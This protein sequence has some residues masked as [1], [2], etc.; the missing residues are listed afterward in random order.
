MKP[1]YQRPVIVRHMV[2]GGNK[3]GAQPS[4]RV[5][6][7]YE[8]IPIG[9][10]VERFGSPLFLISE[11]ILRDRY[12]ELRDQL[13]ARFANFTIA[14]SYKTNYLGAV[15]RVF[16][17]EGAWAEVVS[18]LELQMALKLGMPGKQILFNGPAKS[19][20]DL[21]LAFTVGAHVHFDHLDEIALAERV[22]ERLDLRPRVGLRVNIANLPVPT[23][24]RFGFNLENASAFD[25]A[26]RLARGGRLVLDT[27]HAHIGTFV[28][29]ADAYRLS[30]VGLGTLAGK[31]R[32]ELGL[33]I[34]TLDFGGGFASR[35][36]LQ[37]QYLP[38]EQATP[39][40]AQYVERIAAGLDEVYGGAPLPRV[41]LETGRALVDDAA[42]LVSSVIGN[43]RL[44]DGRRAVVLD[45]GVNLLPTAWWYK[46]DIFPAQDVQGTTEPTVFLGPLC[47]IIDVVR[48]RILF[49]ALRT[50]DRIV[51]N[52][53]GAYNMTQWMQFIA[54]RPNIVM[55]SPSGVAAIV[56]R[57]ETVETLV[58]QEEMPTWLA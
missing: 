43:K 55:V 38:G 18:G 13:A 3:F 52:R 58:Q 8:G 57:A 32:D 45:A 39:T 54:A 25:A 50:G 6:D 12:R 14:W 53:V 23:W 44:T 46:H 30:A 49:P 2:G 56:R 40:F 15:C 35:N 7:R 20:A 5:F 51:V 41:V 9:D 47:M 10:L 27:L 1:A 31:L 28:Q 16:H 4:I 33:A 11:R 37:A 42:I 22:A 21:E 24:D 34:D 29:D 36:T 17:Q 19:E 48:D 26:R